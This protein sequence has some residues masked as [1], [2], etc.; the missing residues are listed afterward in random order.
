[1]GAGPGGVQNSAIPPSSQYGD[2]RAVVSC[3]GWS[4]IGGE[5]SGE[6]SQAV[7]EAGHPVHPWGR[8]HSAFRGTTSSG[9][10]APV[11]AAWTFSHPG[12]LIFSLFLSVRKLFTPRKSFTP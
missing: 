6:C 2:P 4:R 9:L 12:H 7:G 8:V 3:G 5:E 1:M 10:Q 11:L